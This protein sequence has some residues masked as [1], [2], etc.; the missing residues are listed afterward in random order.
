MYLLKDAEPEWELVLAKKTEIKESG[1]ER[2]NSMYE[3]RVGVLAHHG[4][5]N[6]TKLL[7]LH[8]KLNK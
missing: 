2:T 4:G 5:I 8:W 1:V 3:S 6:E 7:L